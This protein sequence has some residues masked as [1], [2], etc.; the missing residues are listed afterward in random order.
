MCAY[1]IL[2]FGNVFIL[3]SFPFRVKSFRQPNDSLEMFP[4]LSVEYCM[5][6]KTLLET[7]KAIHGLASVIETKL[8]LRC[9]KELPLE[10]FYGKGKNRPND[11]SSFCKPCVIERNRLRS[12]K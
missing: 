11:Y 1:S 7:L 10:S 3:K 8:C 6:E 2:H 12:K 4:P 5:K 9:M